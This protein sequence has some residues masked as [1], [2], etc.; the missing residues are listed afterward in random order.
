VICSHLDSTRPALL[1][2]DSIQTMYHPNLTSAP[3]SVGQ[4]REC[5]AALFKTA[6]TLGIAVIIVGHVT[7]QGAIAGPRVLE[8][9][10]DCVLYFEGERHHTYRVI[11]S[12]KNRFGSTNELGVFEM[13]DSGLS[14]VANPSEMLLTGRPLGVPGSVVVCSLE[15][16]RPV[17][18][19]VQA[20]VSYTAFGMPRRMVTGVDYNR[21]VMLMAVLEK[22][23]GL[24]LA[25][26]DAY[27][28]VAGGI[29]VNEPAVD[30]GIALAV[31]S[32]F[33]EKPVD[34][35]TFII[36]EVGLT[37]EVRGVSQ[38]EK[39]VVEA[40]KLGFKRCIIPKQNMKGL[41]SSGNIEIVPVIT[42]EQAIEQ[43]F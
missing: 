41:K 17:L 19:E 2:I 42:V 38:A 39:R 16:S 24:G 26:Q 28:N 31:A 27:I 15:G 34:A 14:E 11:R 1:I 7:K 29:R 5:T 21:V 36:G 32:S 12:V 30:L 37:G 18:T 8:H 10:V 6:K 3:G 25:N 4:V 33:K 43:V 13:C 23:V 35:R 20:L 22:R 9:M 40:E